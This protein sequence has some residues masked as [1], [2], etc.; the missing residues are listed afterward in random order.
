[1]A[2][3]TGMSRES[4]MQKD[5]FS[6]EGC[7]E[8]IKQF[9]EWFDVEPPTITYDPEEPGAILMTDEFLDWHVREGVSLDWT[10]YGGVRGMLSAFRATEFLRQGRLDEL[11]E[12][13]RPKV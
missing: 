11:K 4:A 12:K 6:N 13:A 1:M 10:I 3:D 8:R 2:T 9:C 7:K 5:T